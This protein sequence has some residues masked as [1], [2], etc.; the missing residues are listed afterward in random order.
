MS[1]LPPRSLVGASWWLVRRPS[2]FVPVAAAGLL[3]AVSLALMEVD[4]QAFRLMH[5]VG[6][7]LACA[8]VAAV[9]DPAG[10]VTAASPY[11]RAQRTNTRLLAAGAVVVPAWVGCAT[12]VALVVPVTP[13]LDFGLEGL[14]LA[15][16]GQALGAGLRAWRG[17]HLPAHF[18]A[19]GLLALALLANLLPGTY[20]MIQTQTW[21]PQWEASLVRWAALALVGV[22]MLGLA[23]RDPLTVRRARSRGCGGLFLS[24]S[25]CTLSPRRVAPMRLTWCARSALAAETQEPVACR[26]PWR[27]SRP[28]ARNKLD[29]E[30]HGALSRDGRLNKRDLQ[31]G[32]RVA[33]GSCAAR[34]RSSHL[35]CVERRGQTL[36]RDL[37]GISTRGQRSTG[38]SSSLTGPCAS[39]HVRG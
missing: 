21:G 20:V 32:H 25:S 7:I 33:C 28:R 8:W 14:A 37:A 29:A 18:A 39:V 23:L 35:T 36:D 17:I 4:Y 24:G 27:D 38:W 15:A 6:L 26:L 11:S 2:L 31:V 12:A 13:V 1:R 30:R 34:A 3:T 5:G 10:E 9:D 22:G 16:L 19:F